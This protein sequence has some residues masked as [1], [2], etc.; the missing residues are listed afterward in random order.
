VVEWWAGG[1][2]QITLVVGGLYL[3]ALIVRLYA[4]AQIPLPATEPSAYYADVARSLVQGEGLVSHAVWSYATGPLAVPKPAF[5]L[6]LPMS[7][8]VSALSM[9]VLGP[10]WWAAQVGGAFLGA[11]VAPLTWAVGRGA[12]RG[13]G[14]EARR[15]SAVALA[16][17]L[18]AA[19]LGPLVLASAVPDSYTPFLV[20]ALLTVLLVPRVLGI[21]D[22]APAQPARG[23]VRAAGI[24]LGGA[25][26]LA[27][28]SRQ[29]AIWLGLTV[30]LLL[31][32]ALRARPSGTRLREAAARLWPVVVG[33][34]LVVMP[35]LTR[36]H[37]A[38]GNPLPGQALENMF[39]VR[40][41]DIFAFTDRPSVATYLGQGLATVLGN[42]LA[43]A[44]DGAREVL[45]LTAFPVGVV[46]LLALVAMRRS[47][48]LRRPTALVALL[49]C[50]ALTL[51]STALLFPVAT[52]WGTFMHASGPLVVA[53]I[54]TATLGTDALLARISSR[55]GWARPNV[56][57]GPIALLAVA[58]VLGWLQ[59]GLLA[60]QSRDTQARFEALRTSLD[61]A[62]RELGQVVPAT[63][64]TDH[65]MWLADTLDGNA[66]ALPDEGL[67]SVMDLSRR[68]EAR[69]IVVIDERGR[70]PA[71]LQRPAVA[72]CLEGAPIALEEGATP[73]ILFR[74]AS[75]CAAT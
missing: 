47:P 45:L 31:G 48:A 17:G 57:L 12:A 66:I 28:L 44:W 42:P 73:A 20:F 53:L 7:S 18:L 41:E 51:I 6:W 67:A 9:A 74:L 24:A 71:E 25:M 14:L 75:E 19:V 49:V 37:A 10:S 29:E 62:A 72:G 68:F 2:G 61:E 64:I 38:F 65:P 23:P 21:R 27:Y 63:I 11:L 36:N 33:G 59:L 50:G 34:L 58:A 4:A 56:V 69:W 70:Y 22:G 5:E 26:G 8:F 1:G 16:A 35:W 30:L 60:G 52:R 32:W 40:N 13:T 43:A 39:L 54:V 46:G 3:V 15:A 55:R